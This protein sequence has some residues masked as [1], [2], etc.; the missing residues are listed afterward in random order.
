MIAED[1]PAQ[2]QFVITEIL[3]DFSSGG[4]ILHCEAVMEEDD[5]ILSSM[6]D[7]LSQMAQ[8]EVSEDEIFEDTQEEFEAEELEEEFEEEFEEEVE[9]EELEVE[10]IEPEPEPEPRVSKNKKREHVGS[11]KRKVVKA[12]VEELN[13]IPKDLQGIVDTATQYAGTTIQPPVD[14]GRVIFGSNNPELLNQLDT[15][16]KVQARTAAPAQRTDLAPLGTNSDN[17]IAQRAQEIFAFDGIPDYQAPQS[18]QPKARRKKRTKK[19]GRR[20]PR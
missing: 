8:N 15:Y 2:I 17:V 3:I 20:S 6:H 12:T 14:N 7:V 16:D 5:V 4:L 1:T 10:D 19:G 13:E 9:A 11:K 18:T